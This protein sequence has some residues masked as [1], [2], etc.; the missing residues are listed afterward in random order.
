MSEYSID[1]NVDCGEGYGKWMLGNDAELLKHVTSASIACGGHAGDGLTMRDTVRLCR[2]YKVRMGAHPGFNDKEGFG[3]RMML[4]TPDEIQALIVTQT[5]ALMAVAKCEGM[6]V[7][8]IK[9]HGALFN[10][11]CEDRAVANAVVQSIVCLDRELMLYALADSALAQAGVAAGLRVIAEVYGDRAY[12]TDG[13]LMPRRNPN[14]IVEDNLQCLKQIVH[15]VKDGYIVAHD[16]SFHR[17]LAHSVCIHGDTQGAP[18]RAAY[19]AR[20]LRV[21]D[22]AV[23]AP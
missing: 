12:L 7:Q 13:S 1:I 18:A 23:R 17:V 19:L 9:P 15:A 2:E 4:L 16:G 3:R 11:A 21:E 22:I 10:Q 14:A 8:Y 20:G 5:G 6:R